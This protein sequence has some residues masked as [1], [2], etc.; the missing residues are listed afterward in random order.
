MARQRAERLVACGVFLALAA[1][2]PI[3]AQE[4]EQEASDPGVETEL[5]SVEELIITAQRVAESIQDV[6]IAVTALTDDMLAD[7]Q[8]VTPSDL[9]LNTPNVSF[10]ATNFGGSNFSIRGVG[11]LV[12][13]RSGETGVSSHVNEIAVATNLNT[14]EFFDLERVE[15]LRGPQG[16][17]FGRNATGGALNVVTKMPSLDG[18]DGFADI[19]AGNFSHSRLKG[20]MNLPLT[21]NIAFRVSG[22]KL[23]RDGYTENLAYGQTNAAGQTIPGIDEDIDGRNLWAMRSTLAW[24][25]TDRADV[26]IQYSVFREDDDR[27]RITNQVCKRNPLPTTGCLPDEFGWETPHLGATTA[28]I[29]AGAAGA[30]PPGVSGADPALYD[31]PRPFVGSFRKMHTDFEPVFQMK[32]DLWSFGFNH[33]FDSLQFSVVGALRDYDALAR[34]DYLMD[35]GARLGPTPQNPAGAWPTSEPAGG[36]G[37]EWLSDTCNVAQGTSGLFGGC[38]LPALQTLQF[39]YDQGDSNGTYY[40]VEAKMRSDLDGRFDFLLGTSRHKGTNYGGYYVIANTLD[41]VSLYGS[42]ALGAPPLYPGF[43]YNTNNPE[44]GGPPQDGRATFGEL[45]YEATDRLKFTAGLRFNEDNKIVSDSSVLFNSANVTAAVGGLFGPN[46][47]WL[48]SGMFGEMAAMAANPAATLSQASLRILE[49]HNA[50]GVYEANAPTAIGALVAIGAAQAIG[51][52]IAA[53]LLPIQF[54]PQAIAGLPLP[55]IFQGTVGALLSQNPAV[56]GADAGLAAGAQAFGAIANAVGPAPAFG[57]T[58]FVTGSPSEAQWNEI[59]GRIGF[60]Y[61]LGDNT[62]LYGFFSRGYKPGG[63]NPAIPPAFQDVSAFTFDAEQVNSF[64]VGAKSSLLDG[65]LTLYGAAFTYDYSGLQITRIRNNSSINENVDAAISGLELEGVWRP[66]AMEGLNVD[67]AYSML[68]AKAKDTLSIDPINRTGGNPDYILLNNIDPGSLTGINFV[69][70]ESQITPQVIAAF[71]ASLPPATQ[72]LIGGNL[73]VNILYPPNAAGVAI[74]A[75]FS[76]NLLD[77]LGVETLEGVP[78]NLDGNDLP[79]AP[80]HTA[81]VGLAQSWEMGSAL[82]TLRW[83][84]YWQSESYAREF[85]GVG[86]EIDSWGQHNLMLMYESGGGWSARAW[87]RNVLND[88]NVT[89]KYLTSDTSGFFR[90]Y[91]VTEPKIYGLSLRYVF[92]G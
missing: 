62:L 69:A 86:D 66:A 9:Q 16:T 37:A 20:A 14:I 56:I 78:V 59:S 71:V 24:D 84:Y 1:A 25:V 27:T 60:D 6:P 85:N 91:F 21:S 7:R 70:R 55:P 64:E 42:P 44:D 76:R 40:T 65:R 92:G 18:F 41:L 83:D 35:V 53:G 77:A 81:R 8:I 23:K 89:G 30:L 74:P 4:T 79:N 67:F 2:F 12:I 29:F 57:E 46:P 80:R 33:D 58:R 10:G 38:V 31:F 61:Q 13:S 39:A 87:V 73:G 47:I 26:W 17:L 19:E 45:Y 75:Y 32:E 82:V 5:S 90:N 34:Q 54:V 72:A 51:Q 63:F 49:F 52:Q 22:F 11:Q 3:S 48:R 43:F 15:I 50:G 88:E 28:G 36:A 68:S